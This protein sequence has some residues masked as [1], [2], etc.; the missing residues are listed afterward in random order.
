MIDRTRNPQLRKNSLVA[1][2]NTWTVTIA[3][4]VTVTIIL[5]Y[6]DHFHGWGELKRAPHL[7]NHLYEKIAVPMYACVCVYV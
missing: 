3:I 7:A 6:M 4:L 5:L 2:I 1:I